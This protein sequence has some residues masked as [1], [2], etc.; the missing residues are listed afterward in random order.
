VTGLAR[1]NAADTAPASR[2]TDSPGGH[3]CGM[4]PEVEEWIRGY[5]D[6]SGPIELVHDRP[7]AKV[8]RVATAD[9]VVWFKACAAV[10]AFEPRL[11][12]RL[13]ER[14]PD[15]VAEVLGH[16]EDRAWLLLVD[17]GQPI[18]ALGNPPQLWL[19][20]LPGYAE[21]QRGETAQ[22]EDHVLNGVPDLRLPTLPDRF[23]DLVRRRLPLDADE[24][25]RM[26]GFTNQFAVLCA[27]LSARGIPETIQHDDLHMGNLYAHG[28]GLRFLDWGD[29]SISHPFAS[30]VVT[31]RFL[32][33]RNRMAPSDRWFGRLR[34]AYLEPWGPGLRDTF[35]LAMRVGS[36]AHA[37]AWLRQRDALSQEDRRDF[38][39]GFSIVLRR[40]LA[41]M[42][43]P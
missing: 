11:S 12:A 6:P 39:K 10:Q 25:T 7:W 2:S 20:A 33:E 16:D 15:R 36:I 30:L 37:V 23:D 31:F 40:A 19:A 29:S 34:D 5:V 42:G 28:Q 8:M 35:A 13:F 14:W 1:G 3:S 22:V 18:G 43:R 24:I 26:R 17:A 9:R 21:L 32:E 41:Q 4:D 27:D 38:D